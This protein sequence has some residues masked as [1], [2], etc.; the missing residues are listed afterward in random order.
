MGSNKLIELLEQPTIYITKL[1]KE[2]MNRLVKNI[3]IEL[4][5]EKKYTMDKND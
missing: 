4:F 5:Y 1:Y 3:L 2:K